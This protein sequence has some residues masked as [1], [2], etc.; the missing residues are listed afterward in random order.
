VTYTWKLLFLTA[1]P[2]VKIVKE[3]T[4]EKRVLFQMIG[5]VEIVGGDDSRKAMYELSY[6]YERYCK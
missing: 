3:R 4:K 1:Q 5:A 2:I 6:E